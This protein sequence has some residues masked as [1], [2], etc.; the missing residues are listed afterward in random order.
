MEKLSIIIPAY[1]EEK[2]LAEIVKKVKEVDLSPLKKEI[3]IVD[4]NSTDNTLKI[5]KS[6]PEV[7]VFVEKEKGKGAAVKRGL[8][9]ATGDF[10]L[11]QDADLE[12]NP[13]DIPKLLKKVTSEKTAV[14]GSRNLGPERKGGLLARLGVWFLTKEFNLLFNTDITDLWTCYKLFPKEAIIHFPN[15]GFESEISFSSLLIKNGFD[16]SE[17]PISY[18]SPRTK[19]EGKKIRYRH[20]IQSIFL[21][22]KEKFKKVN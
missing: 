6:I 10:M 8:N 20:G 21:L 14:Y 22:L 19:K 5:A 7:R 12:Y 13:R 11:I 17:V 16:I 2:T 1:N 4:N 3:I 9:V 15:G 18:N